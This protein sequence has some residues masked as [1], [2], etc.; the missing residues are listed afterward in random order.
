MCQRLIEKG[1]HDWCWYL[2]L[3]ALLMNTAKPV[4]EYIEQALA[5]SDN[6]DDI[7]VL[8]NADW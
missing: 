1:Q 6:P 7:D 2:D 5:E 3:D 8:V 4:H